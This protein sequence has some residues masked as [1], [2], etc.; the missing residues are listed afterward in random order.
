MPL[1]CFPQQKGRTMNKLF[2]A[3]ILSLTSVAAY[4]VEKPMPPQ[5]NIWVGMLPF[6]FIFVIFYFLILR[7]QQRKIK[8]HQAMVAAV[9][10]GDKVILSGGIVGKVTK[11]DN[12]ENLV[13]V[14]IAS[15]VVVKVVPTTIASVTSGKPLNDN[16]KK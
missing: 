15:G 3:A 14:E 2:L 12:A 5:E 9:Q 4:A 11:V 13:D 16:T 6:V 8:Q 7:P 10:K 1:Y